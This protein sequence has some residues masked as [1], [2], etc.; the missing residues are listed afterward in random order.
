MVFFFFFGLI[1]MIRLEKERKKKRQASIFVVV[2]L[3]LIISAAV[4]F[5]HWVAKY[6]SEKLCINY[7]MAYLSKFILGAFYPILPL[8]AMVDPKK[9][10]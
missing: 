4:Y 1:K 2:L 7:W 6:V 10:T 9:C 3:F 5:D 8:W